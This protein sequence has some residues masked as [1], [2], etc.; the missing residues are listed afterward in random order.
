MRRSD[1][2]NKDEAKRFVAGKVIAEAQGQGAVLTDVEKKLLYF[3][4]PE[5]STSWGIDPDVLAS[6]GSAY[7][8]KVTNL[9]KGALRRDQE[10]ALLTHDNSEVDRYHSAKELLEGED[11]YIGVMLNE[12]LSA[13]KPVSRVRN[14]LLLVFVVIAALVVLFA[15]SQER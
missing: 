10:A 13:E 14:T 1:F 4:E 6:D 11:D 5:P 9:I 8:E 2:K 3:C 7:E 12:A 15:I